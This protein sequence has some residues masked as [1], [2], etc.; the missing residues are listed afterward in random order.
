LPDSLAPAEGAGAQTP[1]PSTGPAS[2][3]PLSAAL[4]YA[5]FGWQVFPAAGVVGDRCSC[6]R[7]SCDHP[8]KHPLTR[9]GFHEATTDPDQLGR[10]WRRWP[11]AN[12]A[13]ATGQI[14][15]IDVDPRAGGWDSLAL[16]VD[17]GWRLP[18]TATSVTG[19]GGVHLYFR[20]PTQ[21]LRNTVASLPGVPISLPGVD[22]RATGGYVIAPPSLHVSGRRY[23]WVPR[24]GPPTAPPGW[25]RRPAR[26]PRHPLLLRSSRGPE[27]R[28]YGAAA[29]DAEVIRIA[30]TREGSRNHE[31]NRAAFSLGQL[32]GNGYLDAEDAALRM[33]GA[34]MTA[35]LSEFEARRTIASGLEAG[36]RYPRQQ[37]SAQFVEDGSRTAE[38]SA[39][40]RDALAKLPGDENG[41]GGRP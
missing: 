38:S 40:R 7:G 28:A 23:R 16:L 34:A 26:P 20:A 24:S 33:L 14:I 2:V 1:A 41:L 11:K 13:I 31:L 8:G 35:G 15:V 3:G 9:H 36:Q 19:G 25:L 17:E 22:L 5:G 39:A 30:A 4:S 29:L 18:P 6:A 21:E 10:W 12:V 27:R 32:V 37:G